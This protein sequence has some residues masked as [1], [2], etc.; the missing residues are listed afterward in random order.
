MNSDDLKSVLTHRAK[1][2][3]DLSSDLL[4][5]GRFYIAGSSIATDNIKDIDVYPVKDQLFLVPKS[6]VIFQ[7]KNS[8]TVQVSS[9]SIPVQ[10]CKFE[11]SSLVELI[12]SFDFSHIQAGCEI[13]NG[14]VV[15]AQ[16]TESFLY[17]HA[18]KTSEF[19]GSD[20]PLSSII[21]LLKYN[22]RGDISDHSSMVTML[23]IVSE[24]VIRGFKDYEDFKDQLDAVDLG[25]IPENIQDVPLQQL[26]D[27]FEVLK[28]NSTRIIKS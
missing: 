23:S 27:M 3:L 16:W 24:V 9:S 8:T 25:L 1:R 22:K 10:F 11:K 14:E 28:K 12:T 15:D 18:C 6:N 13:S 20:Y 7:T 26:R 17:S 5:K 4:N 19:T 2:C 21:R